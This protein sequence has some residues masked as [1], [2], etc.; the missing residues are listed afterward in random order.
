MALFS[1]WGPFAVMARFWRQGSSEFRKIKRCKCAAAFCM[2]SVWGLA[3]T[4][5][6]RFSRPVIQIL[7]F[8]VRQ[9]SSGPFLGSSPFKVFCLASLR[10]WS[11]STGVEI[12]VVVPMMVQPLFSIHVLATKVRPCEDRFSGVCDKNGCDIQVYR[13]GATDFYGTTARRHI[14]KNNFI[15][16]MKN[17]W[18]T[19]HAGHE[20]VRRRQRFQQWFFRRGLRHRWSWRQN[21]KMK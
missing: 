1:L 7:M 10:W 2:M 18:R 14:V 11:N 13:F 9:F 16:P 6:C 15:F 8:L 19:G 17:V 3:R 12:M 4:C 5:R 20:E 21:G